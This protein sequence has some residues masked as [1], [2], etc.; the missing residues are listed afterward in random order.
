MIIYISKLI[1]IFFLK[2]RFVNGLVDPIQQ[3]YYAISISTLAGQLNLPLWFV[4]LRHAST[5]QHLPSLNVLRN[6]SKQVTLH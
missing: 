1:Y 3:N 4:E 2:K 5:H 6:A